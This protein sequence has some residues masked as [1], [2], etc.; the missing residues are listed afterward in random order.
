MGCLRA[1]PRLHKAIAITHKGKIMNMHDILKNTN[2]GHR[3]LTKTLADKLPAQYATEGMPLAEKMAIIKFFTPAGSWTWYGIE[4][5]PEIR[6]FFGLV[7]G[8]E[9]EFGY[10]S[11]D[12]L[13]SMGGAINRDLHFRPTKI[14]DLPEYRNKILAA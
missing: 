2:R 14:K 7:D 8:F 9:C 13:E 1:A 3:L 4:F 12:E 10:F 5:D 11:L 6:C